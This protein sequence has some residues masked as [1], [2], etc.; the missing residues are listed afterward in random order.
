MGKECEIT[1]QAA[2]D[3]DK[4]PFLVYLALSISGLS[5]QNFL[6]SARRDAI[7]MQISFI[8]L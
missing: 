5:R 8:F 6:Y 3:I 4:E 2:A 7:L 1:R